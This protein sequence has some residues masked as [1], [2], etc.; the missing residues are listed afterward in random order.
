MNSQEKL[1][2][3]RGI[4]HLASREAQTLSKYQMERDVNPI[5][6][7]AAGAM[8]AAISVAAMIRDRAALNQAVDHLSNTIR[9]T[10]NRIFEEERR[11][12]SMQ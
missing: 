1:Q 8:L 5:I 9:L 6:C 10:A 12:A 4:E 3:G 2:I 11:M 7:A